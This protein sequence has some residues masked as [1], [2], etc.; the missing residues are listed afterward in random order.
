MAE[1]PPLQTENSANQSNING[2]PFHTMNPSPTSKDIEEDIPQKSVTIY[3]DQNDADSKTPKIKKSTIFG[4]TFMITNICLGTTIF[5]FATRAKSFGLFWMLFF[6]FVVAIINYWSITRCIYASSRC[7][8][9]D[10]S[11]ITEYFLGRKMRVLLNIILIVYSYA[12]LMCFIALIFPLFGRF[13]QSGF[14]RNEY[15][16]YDH[17]FDEKWGKAY[18]KFPFFIALA[19]V[20]S[21]ICL[22]KDINKLNFS[23][24]IGVIACG[25][26][27]IVVMVQ[28]N[29]YYH[30]YKDTVYDENDDS[31]HPN[32]FN[33]GDA[34]TKDL[35]F[36]KGIANLI[37][38][39]ACQSGIFPIYAGFRIQKDS[40]KKMKIGTILGT[41]LTTA[42]HVISIVCGFLTDPITPEDLIIY[43][44]N[45]GSGRDIAMVIARLLVSISLIFT[46][47]GYYFPLRLSVINS[48]T[49]GILTNKFNILFTF[50][51]IFACAMIS[52]IY[53]KILNYLNYIG[54]IS[55]FISFLFPVLM[56][57]YS[58]GKKV[59][60]W[61]NMLDIIL[62]II[63]C[64]IGLVACV[65]TIIDDVKG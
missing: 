36:F 35:I 7:H 37:F 9:N 34:F 47:P 6:C 1:N 27:L 52:A 51:S 15:R 8:L 19:F 62:A 45:K 28:C 18:I 49:G 41:I 11:E 53:D 2:H 10:Y 38:A 31:T 5:T 42:L 59:T 58:S 43:R 46:V 26:A 40:V 61:K 12:S 39:Y 60:Y 57:V 29:S 22:I 56:N 64:L 48:F 13:I 54:F 16:D 30:H 23:A 21:L 44:K 3:K 20:L 17:F 55:V 14:Y 33:L 24:Y 25:Y 4:A 32:W 50:I 65:A 63:M